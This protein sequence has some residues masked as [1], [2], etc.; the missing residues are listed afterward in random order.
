[1][2]TKI[3]LSKDLKVIKDEEI[4]HL[5]EPGELGAILEW[6]VFDP[7]TGKV[8]EHRVMKSKSYVQQFLQLLYMKMAVLIPAITISIRDTS[9]ALKNVSC[10]V[11]EFDVLAGATSVLYG[12]IIGTGTSA[13]LI[14]NYKIETIIPHATMNY[15]AVTFGL[16]T[17]DETTSQFTVT[18]NFSNVSGFSVTVNEIAL[19]CRALNST[20]YFMIIRDVTGGIVVPNGQTLTVNY[21]PQA[22]V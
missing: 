4:K 9:N 21:R 15:G 8:T 5:L 7:K 12:I 14:N 1:M 2:T 13:P 19:Y 16:P 11:Y 6:T 20:T 10:A 22:V 17:A 3:G 18:R